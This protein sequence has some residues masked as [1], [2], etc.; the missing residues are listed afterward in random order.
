MADKSAAYLRFLKSMNRNV[1]DYLNGIEYDLNALDEM[2]PLEKSEIE[3]LLISHPEKLMTVDISALA[4]IGSPAAIAA[5]EDLSRTGATLNRCVAA[6]HLH[7]IGRLPDLT[8]LLCEVLTAECNPETAYACYLAKI[9]PSEKIEQALLSA[10]WR[11][12]TEDR[13]W[14][15][16]GTLSEIRGKGI[17]LPN[18]PRYGSHDRVRQS[19]CRA[20]IKK[21]CARIGVDWTTVLSENERRLRHRQQLLAASAIL[22]LCISVAVYFYVAS[23]H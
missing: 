15:C 22:I 5:I 19:R 14:Q 3:A 2:S 16:M 21:E 17:E 4:R 13:A 6:E 11:Y 1:Q 23:K 7:S 10:A 20:A 8:D 18:W 9:C 12:P